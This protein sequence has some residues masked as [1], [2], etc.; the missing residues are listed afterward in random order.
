MA[1]ILEKFEMIKS[2]YEL[3]MIYRTI[4]QTPGDIFSTTELHAVARTLQYNFMGL[5]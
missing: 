2:S 3:K 5:Q 4:D 1:N